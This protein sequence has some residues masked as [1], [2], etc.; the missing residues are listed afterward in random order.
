MEVLRSLLVAVQV[1]NAEK[2]R[3]HDLRRGHARDLQASGAPLLEILRAG[4]WRPPAFLTYLDLEQL[5]H[6]A[7]V[8]AHLA[9]SSAPGLIHWAHWIPKVPKW[10]N[11]WEPEH[12]SLVP[13]NSCNSEASG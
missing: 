8:A 3:T 2:H 13:E 10:T 12:L 7:V 9:E 1:P 6:D 5:E 4:E 11:D